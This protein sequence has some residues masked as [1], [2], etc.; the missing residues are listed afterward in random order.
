MFI[1]I[2][3]QQWKVERFIIIVGEYVVLV[4]WSGSKDI[5]CFDR[6]PVR[7][8]ILSFTSKVWSGFKKKRP[9]GK[10]DLDLGSCSHARMQFFQRHFLRTLLDYLPGCVF[11]SVYEFAR[12]WL[13][14]V[15]YLNRIYVRVQVLYLLLCMTLIKISVETYKKDI[16]G[17]C[18]A[19]Y[20][21]E[22]AISRSP[23]YF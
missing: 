23:K 12:A 15:F 2:D 8:C 1:K 13:K 3:V 5:F 19:I 11:T 7:K 21:F 10:R 9:K 14:I 4:S 18:C 6:I 16:L 22:D 20:S 17:P